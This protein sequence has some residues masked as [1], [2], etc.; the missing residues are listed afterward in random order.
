MS[1][2]V[3]PKVMCPVEENRTIQSEKDNCDLNKAV[4]KFRKH[5]VLSGPLASQRKAMFGDFS[6][7]PD[8]F[9]AAQNSIINAKRS[10]G[11]LPARVR[12]RFH[13]DPGE[14]LVFL[15]DDKNTDEAIKL[16]LVT[17]EVKKD[18]APAAGQGPTV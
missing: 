11:E 5:H 15:A 12:E 10:F 14:L 4:A 18:V 8:D 9:M 16:G 6:D 1:S 7:A 17:P 13:N 2:G 3:R